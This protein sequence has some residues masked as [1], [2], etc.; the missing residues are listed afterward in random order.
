[1]PLNTPLGTTYMIRPSILFKLLTGLSAVIG[2]FTERLV[3]Y[4]ESAESLL[5]MNDL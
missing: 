5:I 2:G 3:F 4:Y 1:M